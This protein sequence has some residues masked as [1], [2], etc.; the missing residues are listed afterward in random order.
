M[1]KSCFILLLF[2]GGFLILTSWTGCEAE[3]GCKFYGRLIPFL[4]LQV[5]GA[6]AVYVCSFIMM[7]VALEMHG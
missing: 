4:R 5:D 1:P 3:G 7:K 2:D 6:S